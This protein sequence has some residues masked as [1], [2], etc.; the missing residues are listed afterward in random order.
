MGNA[1]RRRG[2]ETTGGTNSQ[3]IRGSPNVPSLPTPVQEL[4]RCTD[5]R[6]TL[7]GRNENAFPP[8]GAHNGESEERGS[9]QRPVINDEHQ[10]NGDDG[11][12]TPLVSSPTVQR[13]HGGTLD[14]L[15]SFPVV[16][17][18]DEGATSIS[19]D[20]IQGIGEQQ[21]QNKEQRSVDAEREVERTHTERMGQQSRLQLGNHLTSL[22]RFVFTA[23]RGER[24]NA[25]NQQGSR[26]QDAGMKKRKTFGAQHTREGRLVWSRIDRIYTAD[27]VIQRLEHHQEFWAS[28][29]IPVSSLIQ[30]Q[31]SGERANTGPRSAYFKADPLVVTENLDALKQKWQNLQKQYGDRDAIERFLLC[32]SGIRKSIKNMQYEKAQ[33]LQQLPE[34][35]Q[36]LQ[37]LLAR[38]PF[39]LTAAEQEE[40]GNLMVQ[41]RE[42]Q[43]W[44]NHKWRL[45]CRDRFLKEGDM[46]S[47]YFFK[48]FKARRSR[49]KIDKLQT[50]DGRLLQT[51]HEVKDAVLHYFADLYRDNDRLEDGQLARRKF[52]SSVTTKLSAEQKLLLDERP[53]EKELTDILSLL[54]EGKSPGIDGFGVE[55]TVALWPLSINRIR[56][57]QLGAETRILLNGDL[58]PT[59]QVEMGVRQGCPLSP[60]LYAIA[61]IPFIASIKDQNNR[62]AIKP[63]RLAHDVEVSIVCMADDTAV[64]TE[65]HHASVLNLFHLLG[66]YQV[67]TGGRVNWRK[68]KLMVIGCWRVLPAWTHTLP[69]QLIAPKQSVR[70]LG[71]SLSTLWNGIDNGCLL[72]ESLNGKTKVFSHDFMSFDARV[73][74][75]KH[76]VYVARFKTGTVKKLEGTLRKFLWSTN[77][78]GQPKKSLVRWD[79]VTLPEKMG[80]LGV[81][82]IQDFQRALL[83]RS[84]L[85]ALKNPEQAIWPAILSS[86]FLDSSLDHFAESLFLKPL[87][88]SFRLC[89]V[90]TLI[91][92]AW[93]KFVSLFRWT[94]GEGVVFPA[95]NPTDILFLLARKYTGVH[96]ATELVE[97]TTVICRGNQVDSAQQL[98]TILISIQPD[99]LGPLQPTFLLVVEELRRSVS[100]GSRI[101]FCTQEWVHFAGAK[102][103]LAWRSSQ[104][105]GFFLKDAEHLQ[106]ERANDRWN[107]SWPL[108]TWRA[109][110]RACEFRDLGHRHRCFYWRVI[111]KSFFVGRKH[112]Q[113][114]LPGAECDFCGA[115]VEDISHAIFLCPRWSR[116][117]QDLARKVTGW[118]RI[119]DLREQGAALPEVILWIV[120]APKPQWSGFLLSFGESCG[121]K[122]VY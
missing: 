122:D 8:A 106:L 73:I 80:G 39:E 50:E 115:A 86:V 75:L 29:H 5:G 60:L 77:R 42:L 10:L 44:Q 6:Q 13:G 96:E 94:P 3:Q 2:L 88:Q 72:L 79:F 112:L 65:I 104:I 19:M 63:V 62:G 43:A 90:A 22:D 110:W 34:L 117:W 33:R 58:L 21:Q 98:V 78:E 69:L 74:A 121:R 95:G 31:P 26:R 32:W 23:N 14:K 18:S 1:Y 84:M 28:D 119:I 97:R 118:E 116:L 93:T 120:S 30:W 15:L 105:Y 55:A 53:S 7:P 27:F 56:A 89:P 12:D 82:G 91:L 66:Q 36:R 111:A 38:S 35:Q 113:M 100:F 41:T 68:S 103:D 25:D 37:V 108:Q 101:Q 71:A 52:L 85:K 107:L 114:R 64:Y 49:T 87:P 16:Q 40:M 47:A 9:K 54:P 11:D 24:F 51:E 109:V 59:F 99:S 70:Y 4:L 46:C 48:K 83:C 102:L 57:L 61:T 76:G 67:A 92:Q 81:F 17:L 45:T 20:M